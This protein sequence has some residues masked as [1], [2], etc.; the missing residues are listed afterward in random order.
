MEEKNDSGFQEFQDLMLFDLHWRLFQRSI[1]KEWHTARTVTTLALQI[2]DDLALFHRMHAHDRCLLECASSLHDIGLQYGS[3]RHAH[4]SEELILSEDALPVDIIDRGMIALVSS[5]HRGKVRLESD[6]F[7]PLLTKE[8]QHTVLMLASILR[9]AD[10]LDWLRP[11][12]I[13]AVHWYC[14]PSGGSDRNE[15]NPGCIRR[16]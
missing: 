4:R 15:F 5:A 7:F 1:P 6:G 14:R 11:G 8:Q 12:S 2:F 10:G 16:N 9:V 3:K 13:T